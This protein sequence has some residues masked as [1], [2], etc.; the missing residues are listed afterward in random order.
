MIE[1]FEDITSP[2]SEDEL[3]ILPYIVAGLERRTSNNPV[4]SKEIVDSMNRNLAKYQYNVDKRFR[5]TG[6]RLRKMINYLRVKSVL[7]VIA[8]SE[9]YFTTDDPA[10]IEK[11]I[12]S[13]EERA[14]AIVA[15]ADGLKRFLVPG[16]RPQTLF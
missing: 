2:L 3:R 9:G 14:G 4:T 16:F 5:M 7:C 12:R 15:A 8:T 6:A 10:I 13:L 1:N 11:N